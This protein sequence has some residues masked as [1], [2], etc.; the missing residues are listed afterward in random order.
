M[1]L[2]HSSVGK[3]ITIILLN[4]KVGTF[5]P[6]VSV[7][8]YL[9]LFY[10]LYGLVLFHKGGYCGVNTPRMILKAEFWVSCKIFT[11]ITTYMVPPYHLI[12]QS[13]IT[14]YVL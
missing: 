12:N 2:Q 3:S 11:S 7:L 14:E 4:G 6:P 9:M 8:L 1:V 10:L 5:Q 13:N